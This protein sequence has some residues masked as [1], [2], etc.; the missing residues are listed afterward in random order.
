MN[1]REEIEQIEEKY[2]RDDEYYSE[3]RYDEEDNEFYLKDELEN[4]FNE[5]RIKNSV[6]ITEA[7]DSCGYSCSVISVVWIEDGEIE[8]DNFLLECM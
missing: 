4:F 2:L 3:V 5:D 6:E 8:T 1:T 7:F